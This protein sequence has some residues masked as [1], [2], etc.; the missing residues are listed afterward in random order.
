MPAYE[1]KRPF[2]INGYPPFLLEMQSIE[3]NYRL[4]D[5]WP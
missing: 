4:R 2:N 5:L 1:G 3:N